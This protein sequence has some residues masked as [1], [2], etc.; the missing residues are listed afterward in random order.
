MLPLKPTNMKLLVTT[1]IALMIISPPM[2]GQDVDK[3]SEQAIIDL[4]DNYGK[5][6][7]KKDK[8]LL[9][10]I[11]VQDIDQLVS[12]GEW[13][14]GLDESLAG[15]LRSSTRQPGSRSLEVENVRFISPESAIADARYTIDNGDGTKRNMWSTFVAVLHEGQWKI[16]AI[17]NMLP[18]K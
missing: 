6:R 4:V 15:M 10:S 8:D 13:R 18:T 1:I 7:A 9:G 5:A 2:L 17:R 16:A 12:T 14:R 11:L 3:Q